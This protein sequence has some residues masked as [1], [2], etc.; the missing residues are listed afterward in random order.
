MLQH[1][2]GS[3]YS[4]SANSNCFLKLSILYAFSSA[5]PDFVNS[6]HALRNAP[7]GSLAHRPNSIPGK[8]ASP[9]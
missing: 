2:P 5:V 1:N 3:S 8:N 7:F 6:R 4:F 9:S